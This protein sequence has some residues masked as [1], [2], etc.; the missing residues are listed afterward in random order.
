MLPNKVA[1]LFLVVTMVLTSN[2]S[3]GSSR[4]EVDTGEKDRGDI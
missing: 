3:A 2:D 4:A 1:A